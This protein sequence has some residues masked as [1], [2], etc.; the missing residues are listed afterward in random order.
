[1][2]SKYFCLEIRV[3]VS[4][5]LYSCLAWLQHIPVS[6]LERSDSVPHNSAP[7]LQVSQEGE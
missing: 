1:M 5:A 4:P 6:C 3:R 2:D 7:I